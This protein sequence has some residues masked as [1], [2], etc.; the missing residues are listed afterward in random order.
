MIKIKRMM[1]AVLVCAMTV[2]M[3][4]AC[5]G[6]T[7]GFDAS[8]EIGVISREDGSGTRSAFVELFGVEQK[9]E[10]GEKVDYTVQTAVITKDTSVMM[11]TVSGDM[12]AM[13]YISLGSLNDTVK[14][15]RIN[16]VDAT[17]ENIKSGA[18]E[19]SRPFNIVTG[20]NLSDL[21]QDF[22]AYIL[23]AD[24]QGII[25]SNNYISVADG[26][27]YQSTGLSGKLVISGSSSVTPVMEK[28]KEG[29]EALNAGVT[30]EIQQHDSSTGIANT[31]DGTCD[32]GMASRDLKDAE[33]EAGVTAMAI[34]LDGIAVIVN[35]ACPVNDLTS[36]QIRDIFMGTITV[37]EELEQ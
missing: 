29:Y 20:D 32:I 14:A 2:G 36:E 19:I 37:W 10:A 33:I 13:G 21:A 23:S 7:E 16:G 3:M 6:K 25:E 35:N 17:V 15:V 27:R 26:E 4:T 34:A 5:G 22:I 31:I 12:Y 30:I 11:T 18:Y 24:G 28:L 8:Q 9:N 1:S